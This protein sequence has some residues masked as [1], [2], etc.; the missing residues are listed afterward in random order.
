MA[1]RL[2][3]LGKVNVVRCVDRKVNFSMLVEK[4][5][6]NK[7]KGDKN[8]ETTDKKEKVNKTLIDIQPCNCP[9]PAVPIPSLDLAQ[10]HHRINGAEHPQ[11]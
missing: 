8:K 9:L 11:G 10:I 1:D 5:K 3:E 2:N 4:K 7:N 6:I